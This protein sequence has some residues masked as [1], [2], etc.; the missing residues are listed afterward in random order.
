LSSEI[1][2]I[3]TKM[4]Y[5]RGSLINIDLDGDGAYDGFSFRLRNPPVP[6]AG[7]VVRMIL[8]VDGE[9]VD[10]RRVFVKI[11]DEIRNLAEISSSSPLTYLPG[12]RSVFMVLLGRG[13]EEGR[14]RIQIRSWLE[15]FE[16]IWIPLEFEDEV[17]SEEVKL[18]L[19][20]DEGA[21]FSRPIIIS[22]NCA[23]AVLS[24]AGD[25][26]V[27]WCWMGVS[28]DI[29]G[30]YVPPAK[31]LGPMRVG[32]EAGGRTVM[33]SECVKRM[34]H[35]PGYILTE[36][37]LD[38]L[39]ITRR[40]YSPP[41]RPALIQ[42]IELDG[43][44]TL[45][46]RG[47]GNLIPYGLLGLTPS[48][49][50][51]FYDKRVNG[52]VFWSR[53]LGYYGAIGC[54]GK[55]IS[56][57]LDGYSDVAEITL[58]AP[59]FELAYSADKP[60]R[61]VVSGSPCDLEDALSQ[62]AA[63]LK[64]SDLSHTILHYV[65][66]L[67]KTT[68]LETD[69]PELNS[70]FKL[71]KLS[72][73]YL[74]LRHPELGSGIMAG[75]PRFPTFWGRDLG[76]TLQAMINI[77]EW[78]IVRESLENVLNRMRDGEIPMIIGGRGFL[79]STSYGSADATLYYPWLIREYVMGS[80]DRQFLEKWY[81]K[82]VEMVEW[83][84]GRDSDGDGLLDHGPST[85]GFLPVPDTTWMD[86][87]DR[88]KSA[89]EVQALWVK[90][91]ESASDLA[92]LVGDGDRS[93][94]WREKAS[95][96]KSII[97]KR[98]W[99][100]VEEYFYDTIRPSGEP[101]PSVRPN[102]LVPIMLGYVDRERA[103]KALSRASKPDMTT[104][105]GVRT[106]SSLDP[107]YDPK[108]Y[109]DGCVWPLVTGWA[110]AAN[111]RY[112]RIEEAFNLIKIMAGQILNEAGMY[113]ELYR[114]DREES[115]NACILQAWSIASYI[116]SLFGLL[117]MERN[118]LER[119]LKISPRIPGELTNIT[120]KRIRLGDSNLT[121]TINRLI[122]KISIHHLKGL[123]PI[124]VM[125]AGEEEAIEPGETASFPIPT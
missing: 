8:L 2:R 67:N 102:A 101:D 111:L 29:G 42:D 64:K 31:I 96:L 39:R 75:L 41:G 53:D 27:E 51:V 59:R 17:E 62:A 28:Y 43:R 16:D 48:S 106:L 76:W 73:F 94:S 118:A 93:K 89:I 84:F 1:G 66:Y 71:G 22:S 6:L 47:V 46:V 12:T 110:A 13:L 35:G 15:G 95:E 109:H 116:N 82:V 97:V 10:E 122:E 125:V 55:L 54:S 81:P 5:I 74:I 99:N 9:R 61:V 103:L 4:A 112:G 92:E 20:R 40:T 45:I 57:T 104:P 98:Y 68:A 85:T 44:A 3:F 80:G 78:D 56:Y 25:P 88:G 58:P 108:A 11:R 114:G 105:W 79:H 115:F 7:R 32:V 33:L 83:G 63:G 36:H 121:I 77:S 120:L 30:L 21:D 124:K 69:D 50:K 18:E 37:D 91:L 38:G 87:I 65:T 49:V 107:K 70:A 34:V 117:G 90:A 24:R 72:L 19:R 86:H 14:H 123:S 52:L 119:S 113:A 23:Y 26:S 60:V 100:P